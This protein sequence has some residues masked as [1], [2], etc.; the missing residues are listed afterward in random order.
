MGK[1]GGKVVIFL[2]KKV[3]TMKYYSTLILYNSWFS[4]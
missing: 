2:L 3:K 4:R 1:R